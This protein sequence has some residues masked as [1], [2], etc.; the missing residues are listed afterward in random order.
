M[1]FSQFEYDNAC[2]PEYPDYKESE[3][4]VDEMRKKFDDSSF[5]ETTA[6]LEG[7]TIAAAKEEFPLAQLR[8]VLTGF[9]LPYEQIQGA[10]SAVVDTEMYKLSTHLN[11]LYEQS[12]NEFFEENIEDLLEELSDPY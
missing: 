5:Y 9:G 8:K 7:L 3:Y 2:E 10:V 1:Y 4:L 6:E 12:F 11:S